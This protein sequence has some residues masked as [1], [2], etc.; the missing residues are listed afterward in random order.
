MQSYRD[1]E[2]YRL[3]HRLAVE[4]SLLTNNLPRYELYETG[5]Q[6]RRSAKSVPANIVEGFTRKRYQAEYVRFLVFAHGSC[7]E[8]IEHLELLYECKSLLNKE[9]YEMLKGD[10]EKLGGMLNNFIQSVS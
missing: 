6:I 3:A 4:I 9:K 1:L 5:S 8:T 7:N 10:Y 2:I